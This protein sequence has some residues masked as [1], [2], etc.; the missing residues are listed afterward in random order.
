[1]VLSCHSGMPGQENVCSLKGFCHFQIPQGIADDP[2]KLRTRPTT[3]QMNR[4]QGS[5]DRSVNA[6]VR[7]IS[8]QL[9]P[10]PTRERLVI[11]LQLLPAVNTSSLRMPQYASPPKPV[12]RTFSIFECAS[13]CV[14]LLLSQQPLSQL[15]PYNY[16]LTN[17]STAP[18]T[19]PHIE[20]ES[21]ARRIITI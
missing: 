4:Y 1:M 14:L 7:D 5:S 17:R 10:V 13:H 19:A 12:T 2:R 20:R 6:I 9:E 21:T 16:N 8:E 11:D 3:H 18:R 15:H